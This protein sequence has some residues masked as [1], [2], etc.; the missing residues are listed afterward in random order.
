MSE[1]FNKLAKDQSMVSYGEKEVI[2]ALKMGAVDKLLLSESLADKKV[3]IFEEE[4]EKQGTIV[5]MISTE[6]GEG[7]QLKD[8]GKV[9]AVL[10][11]KLSI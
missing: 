11:Y 7:K 9:A 10:R 4:A 3:E 6:T 5:E 8:I 2:A 1:F